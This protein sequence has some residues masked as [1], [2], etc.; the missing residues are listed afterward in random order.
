MNDSNF[1][2]LTTTLA[3]SIHQWESTSTLSLP[4]ISK[5]FRT[6]TPNKAIRGKRY[7]NFDLFRICFRTELSTSYANF[8]CQSADPLIVFFL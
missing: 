7:W 8:A 1:K 4:F 5:T 2:A 3:P 6:A